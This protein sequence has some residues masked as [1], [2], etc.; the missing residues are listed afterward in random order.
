M[1]KKQRLHTKHFLYQSWSQLTKVVWFLCRV[2]GRVDIHICLRTVTSNHK[3]KHEIL[4]ST[5][6]YATVTE[7]Y[8]QN[9]KG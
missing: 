9:V 5:I 3:K 7:Y 4:S 2:A 6:R 1:L 8:F